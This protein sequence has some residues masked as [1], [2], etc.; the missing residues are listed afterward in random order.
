MLHNFQWNV[1]NLPALIWR[2]EEHFIE[3]TKLSTINYFIESS[4]YVF[5]DTESRTTTYTKDMDTLQSY[6]YYSDL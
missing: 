1:E 3:S 4:Y 2:G 5:Q 6:L